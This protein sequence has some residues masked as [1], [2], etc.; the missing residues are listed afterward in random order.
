M[1]NP[2]NSLKKI[3]KLHIREHLQIR[4]IRKNLLYAQVKNIK[5]DYQLKIM[6]N[7]SKCPQ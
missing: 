6:E 5:V 1:R 4:E 3:A 7:N 2:E